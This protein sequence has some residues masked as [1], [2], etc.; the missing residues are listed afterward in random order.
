MLRR[1]GA[2]LDAQGVQQALIVHG[3]GVDEVAL[4]AETRAIRLDDGEMEEIVITPE[5]A[6]L[7]RAPLGHVTGGD[8]AENAARLR[9]LLDGGGERAERD[10]VILNA[11]ALLMTASKAADLKTGVALAQA[12]LLNGSAARVL[13]DFIAETTD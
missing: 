2:T 12:A 11:G 6:G 13:D 10:V 1:V 9:A 4:H 8:P 3:G 7:E 5:E